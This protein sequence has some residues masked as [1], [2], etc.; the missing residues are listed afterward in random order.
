L[1]GDWRDNA[2]MVELEKGELGPLV[3]VVDTLTPKQYICPSCATSL[4]VEIGSV[5]HLSRSD[6]S[7]LSWAP[8]PG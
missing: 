4:W 2:G 7:S 3:Q 5:Q 1:G 8:K 6:F